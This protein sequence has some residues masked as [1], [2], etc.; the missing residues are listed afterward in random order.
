MMKWKPLSK[1][2]IV[3]SPEDS[4]SLLKGISGT[5]QNQSNEKRRIS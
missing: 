5:I 4:G 1:S 3:K 2:L